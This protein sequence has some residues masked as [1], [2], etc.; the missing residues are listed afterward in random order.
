MKFQFSF[1]LCLFFIYGLAQ[2]QNYSSE[3]LTI[4][5]LIDGTLLTPNG[6]SKP[7]L[8]ILIAG[9]GP[10]DRNG[11][12]NFLKNNVLKKLAEDLTKDGTA[13]FRYDKRIV[14]Q[15]KTNKID[16]TVSFDDFVNDAIEVIK[17]FKSTNQYNHIFIIGHSQGSLVGMLAAKDYADG[18]ISIAG[19][20]RS[21]DLVI[22]DQLQTN[23]PIYY[24]DAKRIFEVLKSGQTTTDYP[25]ELKS[26]F[27]IEVQ[28]FIASWMKYNPTEVIKGLNM[29][30]LIIN[31]TNDLQVMPKEAELLHEAAPNSTLK[32]I[33]NMNHVLVPINGDHIE[34]AK[35][36]NES[37]RP[38]APELLTT[39]E[40]FIK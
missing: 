34:N 12:Q 38:I 30:V 7:N 37:A 11:N 22:M 9:S 5:D 36:Y 32:I 14:K 33:D 16:N 26:I 28:P 27:N 35:S 15:I 25:P 24:E 18:F 8:G 2:E 10:T 20:G 23:A 29:P 4:T 17:Y 13:T 40:A 19:A 3:D 6:V 39:I 21:I 31:G 1:I